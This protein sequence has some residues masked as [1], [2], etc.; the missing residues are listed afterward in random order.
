MWRKSRLGSRLT[1]STWHLHPQPIST[2]RPMFLGLELLWTCLS[3][4]GRFTTPLPLMYR[5]RVRAANIADVRDLCVVA[6]S[7]DE[8]RPGYHV[9]TLMQ[10]SCSVAHPPAVSRSGLRAAEEAGVFLCTPAQP[11][12]SIAAHQ[13]LLHVWCLGL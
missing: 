2:R 11:R 7:L 10:P 3:P 5:N 6:A 12:E 4:D 1:A 8:A 13:R 9:S